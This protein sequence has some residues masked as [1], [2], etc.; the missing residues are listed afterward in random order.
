MEKRNVYLLISFLL[1]IF[2]FSI[3]SSARIIT[4]VTDP[5]GTGT[6]AATAGVAKIINQYNDIDFSFWT[7]VGGR[8]KVFGLCGNVGYFAGYLILPLSLAI[9]LFFA[10]KNRNRK[11]L[12]L[13]GIL[14]MGTTLIVT[15]TRSSY[16]A[17]GVS[18]IF[19]FLLFLLSRGKNFLKK[20]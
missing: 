12:L 8:G 6:Y 19:M 15:F 18:L 1:F 5:M 4:I 13:I 9:P 20:N 11:I 7:S 14:V 10:S 3:S 17:L 16:L 2:V